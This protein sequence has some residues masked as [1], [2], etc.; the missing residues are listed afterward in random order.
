MGDRTQKDS[1]SL[2]LSMI[3]AYADI[4][5]SA[6]H[7]YT[8]HDL[9]PQSHDKPELFPDLILVYVITDPD[10]V[11]YPKQPDIAGICRGIRGYQRQNEWPATRYY[12]RRRP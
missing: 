3:I 6:G 9:L 12:E 2:S 8:E 4:P 7:I 11:H 1:D 10:P 5:L